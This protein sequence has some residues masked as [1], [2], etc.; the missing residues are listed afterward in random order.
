MEWC[1]G[2]GCRLASRSSQ[3]LTLASSSFMF[4]HYTYVARLFILTMPGC[5]S[6]SFSITASR[7][8]GGTMTFDSRRTHPS[9]TLYSSFLLQKSLRSSPTSCSGQPCR[10]NLLTN[11]ILLCQAPNL[12]SGHERCRLQVILEKE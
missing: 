2:W 5:V 1:Y 4:S 9:S 10:I 7:P 6:C 11:G 8:G 12:L 3:A